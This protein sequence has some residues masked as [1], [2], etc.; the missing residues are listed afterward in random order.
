MAEPRSVEILWIVLDTVLI[1]K[2]PQFP[3]ECHPLVMT[4]LV[5]DITPDAVQQ[6]CAHGKGGVSLLPRKVPAMP[7]IG[8]YGRGLFKFA[9]ETGDI[10][11]RFKAH[12]K[13]DVVFRP[14]YASRVAPESTDGT[15]EIF[16]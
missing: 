1:Q 12:E 10:V 14:A 9:H 13:V 6:A 2:F 7:A 15:T 3:R 16:E 11:R 8:P 5:F 4:F